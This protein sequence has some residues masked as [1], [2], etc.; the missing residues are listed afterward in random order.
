MIFLAKLN[1][2]YSFRCVSFLQ[3]NK[4]Q[5]MAVFLLENMSKIFVWHFSWL[6]WSKT[7]PV[8]YKLCRY[9][10]IKSMPQYRFLNIIFVWIGVV[11]IWFARK[12]DKYKNTFSC[13]IMWAC[14]PIVSIQT[15]IS[16]PADIVHN[17]NISYIFSYDMEFRVERR[18]WLQ[19]ESVISCHHNGANNC[20]HS[21]GLTHS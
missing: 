17:N 9:L 13:C 11:I 6:F 20:W 3:I 19:R 8:V 1:S 16:K 7:F 21:F 12:R 5:H 2:K 10:S 18:I 4:I 14:K 15:K